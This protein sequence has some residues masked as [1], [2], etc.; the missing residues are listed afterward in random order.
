MHK[1]KWK[2]HHGTKRAGWSQCAI[3]THLKKLCINIACSTPSTIQSNS[4]LSV[5]N[6]VRSCY[7]AAHFKRSWAAWHGVITTTLCLYSRQNKDILK[8][9]QSTL[10]IL[11]MTETLIMPDQS[12][13][14]GKGERE[15]G[16]RETKGW[17]K[18]GLSS[19]KGTMA[20]KNI[21]CGPSAL[22]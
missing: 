14:S 10:Y 1:L 5:Q 22:S 11:L 7:K 21:P 20:K 18:S 16:R 2:Y 3:F 13:S 17:C 12:I 6:L 15:C 19:A 4:H 9:M 8:G